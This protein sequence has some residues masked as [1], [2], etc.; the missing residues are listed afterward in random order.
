MHDHWFVCIRMQR[1]LHRLRQALNQTS[2]E[3]VLWKMGLSKDQKTG[4]L[5]A[6]FNSILQQEL[7]SGQNDSQMG[8]CTKTQQEHS[9]NNRWMKRSGTLSWH[10]FVD[11]EYLHLLV[12]PYFRLSVLAVLTQKVYP[13]SSILINAISQWKMKSQHKTLTDTMERMQK[14]RAD[15]H[16]W[17]ERFHP[18]AER[19]YMTTIWQKKNCK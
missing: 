6:Y 1:R 11:K 8:G 7:L 2:K 12:Q 19:Q 5:R 15:L 18:I 10:L 16:C 4:M 9:Q 14:N 17:M 13:T 3:N